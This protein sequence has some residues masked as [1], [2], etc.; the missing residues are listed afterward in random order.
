MIKLAKF[1]L[2]LAIAT[3]FVACDKGKSG[4][5]GG[6]GGATG[7]AGASA[8][9]PAQGGL[10]RA[11]AAMPKETDIVVGIDFQ[12]LRKSAVFKKY[13]P[14]IMEKVG[15]DLAEFKQK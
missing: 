6:G 5:G 7:A 3:A 4:G 11:L 8:I 1:V 12:Q 9:S 14:Q 2:P 15:K 13:E 10:R